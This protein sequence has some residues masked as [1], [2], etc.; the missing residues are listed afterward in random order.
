MS[1]KFL[2]KLLIFFILLFLTI[3]TL[4]TMQVKFQHN[5]EDNLMMK[6]KL[7]SEDQSQ[8]ISKEIISSLTS[9]KS[10]GD[11]LENLISEDITLEDDKK[12]LKISKVFDSIN[13]SKGIINWI[14][15]VSNKSGNALDST[16]FVPMKKLATDLRERQWYINASKYTSPH[17]TDVFT[18]INTN[19]PCITISYSIYKNDVFIGI[20]AGDIFLEDLNNYFVSIND[21]NKEYTSYILSPKGNIIIS[22]NKSLLGN[23][24]DDL[25]DN[26]LSEIFYN[27]SNINKFGYISSVPQLGWKLISISNKDTYNSLLINNLLKLSLT[28]FILFFLCFFILKLIFLKFYY[29][30]NITSLYNKKKLASIIKQSK[31]KNINILFVNMINIDSN[32]FDIKNYSLKLGTILLDN[33]NI[34]HIGNGRFA[35]ILNLIDN[36]F[37]QNYIDI[38]LPKFQSNE[39]YICILNFEKN[40]LI[41]FEKSLSNVEKVVNKVKNDNSSCVYTTYKK[42]IE[43]ELQMDNRIKFLKNAI[44]N[45]LIEPFF[46]PILNINNGEIEKYEVLMRIKQDG[47]YLNPYPYIVLAEKYN[48]IKS[49]DLIILEKAMKYKR[50]VDKKDN[51]IFSLNVSGTVLGNNSYFKMALEII[52]KYKVGHDKIIFELTETEKIKDLEN[53]KEIILEYKQKGIK[54]ALD[55]FGSGYSTINYLKNIPVDFMKIDGSFIKDMNENHSNYYLVKSMVNIAKA[56]NMKTVGEFTENIEILSSLTSLGVDFAQGY[57]IGKPMN[58]IK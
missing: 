3:F 34:Y 58:T 40:D 32:D 7:S 18:D 55:D 27:D 52:D 17:I 37:I 14:Y 22:N 35:V 44:K 38:I 39:S 41:E 9:L 43:E 11:L 21:N 12:F 25:R 15:Y 5:L 33:S 13:N 28:G 4:V 8:F 26:N 20:L 2:N 51:L 30:D 50:E 49:I 24:I 6:L 10:N 1:K 46:Q 42:F 29:R 23:S 56:Y 57:H 53:L 16:G 54:F 45:D 19:K 48:I 36:D 31:V 47:E